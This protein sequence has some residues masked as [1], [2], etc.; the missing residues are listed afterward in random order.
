LT[1]RSFGNK[2]VETLQRKHIIKMMAARADK[3][4]SANGLRKALRTM[5]KH[6]IDIGLR[7]DDPTQGVKSI[8]PK[9]RTGFHRWTE[10]KIAQFETHFPIGTKA[11]LALAL[12]LHTGSPRPRQSPTRRPHILAARTPLDRSHGAI[13]DGRRR[14]MQSAVTIC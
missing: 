11:R 14:A 8:Q 4:E 1:E 12:G 13:K 6:A 2:K 9:S 10:A 7:V 5:M 3:P